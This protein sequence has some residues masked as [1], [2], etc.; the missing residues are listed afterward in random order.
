M[1]PEN[2]KN[3]AEAL[4]KTKTN[5]LLT[6]AA[7]VL[8]NSITHSCNGIRDAIFKTVDTQ[9]IEQPKAQD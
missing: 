4:A 2:P 3:K 7:V 9:T 5:F 6:V 1:I 8:G